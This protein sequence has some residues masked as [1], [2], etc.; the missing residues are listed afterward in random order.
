MGKR[1]L[2]LDYVRSYINQHGYAPTY[3]EIQ[4]GCNIP[5]LA[6]I[7]YWLTKLSADG[8]LRWSPGV[9]RGISLVKQNG[10]SHD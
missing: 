9:T 3:R 4:G 5:S 8:L 7:R 10:S 2:I 1:E 6:S